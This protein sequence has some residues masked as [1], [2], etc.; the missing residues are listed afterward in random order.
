MDLRQEILVVS[1][2]STQSHS[3]SEGS[4]YHKIVNYAVS[5]AGTALPPIIIF[6][7]A[8]TCTAYD[9]QGPITTCYAKSS[10]GFMDEWLFYSWFSKLFHKCSTWEKEYILII[11]GHGLYVFEFDRASH[12]KGSCTVLFTTPHNTP[13]S[14]FGCIC[15]IN[16]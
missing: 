9:T 12:Y 2:G 11:N 4:H 10:N 13:S 7:K 6:E 3:Q 16:H 5:T 15:V 14:T 8:F 1:C